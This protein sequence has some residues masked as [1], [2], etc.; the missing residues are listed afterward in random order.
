MN[1]TLFLWSRNRRTD[2]SNLYAV[3]KE[4]YCVFKY[5][6]ERGMKSVINSLKL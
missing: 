5:V 6:P 3:N 1:N 2:C 4:K